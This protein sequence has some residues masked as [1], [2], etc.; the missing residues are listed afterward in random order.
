M[1]RLLAFS[2]SA[3]ACRFSKL[4]EDALPAPAVLVHA[5]IEKAVPGK[6]ISEKTHDDMPGWLTISRE[7]IL[8][9]QK[10]HKK[11]IL[12]RFCKSALHRHHAGPIPA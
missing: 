8:T 2:L 9:Q 12:H 5:A 1:M 6:I 3:L 10:L 4:L 11:R 7:V